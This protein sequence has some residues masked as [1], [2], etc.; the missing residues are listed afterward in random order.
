MKYIKLFEYFNQENLK[1]LKTFKQRK[2]VVQKEL[3]DKKTGSARAVY[4]LDENRVLKLA[5]NPK[6]IA[7]NLTEIKAGTDKEF[8]D[9][10]TNIL[11]YNEK[12]EWLIAE[13]AKPISEDKFKELTTFQFNGFM[14]WLRGWGGEE[15]NNFYKDKPFAV[16][17]KKLT[18]K[19]NLDVNDLLDISA[20]GKTNN[21]VVLIDYGL[22][23]HTSRTL[24]KV[25]Y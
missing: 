16:K 7:Q 24:Y 22:D 23:L 19:Y 10:V 5:K 1:G 2:D 13:R 18:V 21:K 6:G 25:G 15:M 17:I 20:W 14:H 9:I 3:R 8:S 12:G 11:E 4:I